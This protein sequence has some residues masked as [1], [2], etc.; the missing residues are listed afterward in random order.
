ME[1]HFD[2]FYKVYSVLFLPLLL[3]PQLG[4]SG[5]SVVNLLELVTHWKGPRTVGLPSL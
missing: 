2:N 5:L 1:R 4:T 3:S